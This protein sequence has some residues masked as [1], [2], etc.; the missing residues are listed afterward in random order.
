M[1]GAIAVNQLQARQPS[2][3]TVATAS[4]IGTAIE[5]YDFFLYG[6]AAALIFNKLFFPT[7]DPMMG[8]LLAFAT[9]ALGFIARPLG[10]VVFGHYGDKIGRKTMLYLTLLIMGAATAAIGFL[11]TYETAGI[12]AA[13]LLVTCRLIQGF[14]LGGEWGGA[15][16]M[17]VEHAPADKKGFYGSW[18]QLGAPLGL[19]LG[20]LVFSVVSAMLTDAQLLAWGWRIPFL[21]SI[22]LV[23]VGLWI[24][25]TIAESP[26]FQKVKDSKQEVKMPILE[27][28]RMYP[29]N[30]LL[31]MGARFAENGFFYIYAT[32]VLAYATQSLGMNKQDMLNGVLIG[33]AIETFTIPAF[34]ALSDRVGRRPVYIFGGVLG[35]DVVPAVHAA[36]D[37]EPAICLDRDRAGPRH[38]PRRDVRAAGELPVG[39]VRHQGALQRRLARL[40]PRLDLRR[41]AVAADRNGPDDGLCAGDLADLALHDRARDHHHRVGLLRDRNTQ[42]R[43]AL[44]G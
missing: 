28:L 30:I 16:L 38:R 13:V 20:T 12:W 23:L 37:Q 10:G 14:G 24:R 17:A 42:G 39:A 19:V 21:F 6:T 40:Q 43:S 1:S 18:P 22:A 11:P 27:A 7:F 32:F 36:G 26:E 3:V 5:W 4:L 9:Y 35:A 44:N 33:A 34:G 29:K 41:R 31:A 8:T 25:F 2:H 15:V